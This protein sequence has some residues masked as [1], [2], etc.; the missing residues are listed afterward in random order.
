M[1]A[2]PRTKNLITPAR[3]AVAGMAGVLSFAATLV[4]LTAIQYGFM[5]SIGWR[6]IADPGGAWPSGL[7]LG[8]HGW[9]MNVSF[10]LSGALLMV[11][12]VGLRRRLRGEPNIGPA[13]LFASGAAMALMSFE[14]DPILREGPRSFHGW[15]HDISFIVFA[16]SLLAS[17]FFLWNGFRKDAA[18]R[19]HARYTL[20]TGIMA[21]VCLVLPGVAYYLFIAVLLAWIFTTAMRL[22][23]VAMMRHPAA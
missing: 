17:M 21:I 8:P 15:I 6:P 22:R 13:L 3:A 10:I 16:I 7:A 4:F 9:I 1:E 14:T 18:W 5:L 2:R 11:F 20:A 12:A 23:R 19:S